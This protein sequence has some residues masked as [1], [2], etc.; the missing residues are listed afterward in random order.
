MTEWH[1]NGVNTVFNSLNMALK[2]KMWQVSKRRIN[3]PPFGESGSEQ[4][5]YKRENAPNN[6]DQIPYIREGIP[7]FVIHQV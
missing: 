2:E 1:L 5:H 7:V 3:D 6:E 4:E